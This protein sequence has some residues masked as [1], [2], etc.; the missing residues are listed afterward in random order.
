VSIAWAGQCLLLVGNYSLMP[1]IAIANPWG[2]LLGGDEVVP[3]PEG[4]GLAPITAMLSRCC[5]I[6]VQLASNI[7]SQEAIVEAIV[8]LSDETIIW[9]E[10]E[11]LMPI[12]EG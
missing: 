7:K 12:L 2:G 10:G 11:E 9:P 8:K 4:V 1:K 5:R 3:K 6:F